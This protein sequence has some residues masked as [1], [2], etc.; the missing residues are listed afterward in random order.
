MKYILAATAKRKNAKRHITGRFD[1]LES[2]RRTG[3]NMN[4][5]YNVEIYN[6]KWELIEK[7]K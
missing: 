3:K 1:D 7:V 2:A 6:G 4:D 5:S